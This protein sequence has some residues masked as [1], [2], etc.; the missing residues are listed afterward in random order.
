[1]SGGSMTWS[2]MLTRI[3]S[4]VRTEAPL[5]TRRC[6]SL[7]SAEVH[8]AGRERRAEPAVD[9]QVDTVDVGRGG[10][11]EERQHRRD[12]L[13]RDG[14]A[15]HLADVPVHDL[16]TRRLAEVRQQ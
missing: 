2:S 10:R 3:M 7:S 13:G 6:R 15:V 4:P 11:A 16:V 8:L 14:A 1:M 5:V 12:L 9:V